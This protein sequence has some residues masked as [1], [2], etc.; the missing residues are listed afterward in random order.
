MTKCPRCFN[1]LPPDEFAWVDT[2]S[3]AQRIDPVASRYAGHD[4]RG[5][6][7]HTGQAPGSDAGYVEVC[8]TCHYELPLNWRLGVATCVTMAGARYTGKTVFIAVLIKQLQKHAE[9]L[10]REVV[11]ANDQTYRRYRDEYEGPLFD[12]RGIVQPTPRASLAG[13]YQHEPLI[14][15]L[16]LWGDV[17]RFLVIRDV[18]GED[19]E[20]ADI[21]GPP[22][23]F[24]SLADA[25][26]FLFDPMRVSEI[27]DQLRDLV[28][29]SAQVGGDPR[30]VL[31]TVMRLI[32]HGNP[33]L[34]VVL[35]KFDALQALSGVSSSRWARMMSHPGAAFNRDPGLLGHAYDDED[36]LL[37]NAEVQSLLQ[38][39]DAG[40]LLTRVE[41]YMTGH[42]Y[43]HR[44][45]AVSALGE[46]PEGEKLHRSGISPFRCADPVRWVFAADNVL[47]D[48][49]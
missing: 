1:Y 28:P 17:R 23:Q 48:V 2:T 44:F 42:Q 45:F 27:A 41:N 12:Q 10:G 5:G 43:E 35:S 38:R 19:L 9:L 24:F 11:P 36:G 20:S 32:G 34:A 25:V 40:P 47:Q 46:T 30:E 8:P 39:L 14:F 6:E 15:N 26:I 3:P 22:W 31:R 33:K 49:R 4:I 37:L 16:G 21:G 7:V 18:A 13:S 29:E